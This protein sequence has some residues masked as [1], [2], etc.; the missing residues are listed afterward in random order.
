MSKMK[1]ETINL[2]EGHIM[3]DSTVAY[4]GNS[5]W[6]KN[7]SKTYCREQFHRRQETKSPCFYYVPQVS[8]E[9]F[10]AKFIRIEKIIGI[11]EHSQLF[12]VNNYMSRPCAV[13]I[14]LSP[15][16]KKY[17]IRQQFLTNL[18]RAINSSIQANNNTDNVFGES[19]YFRQT[20]YSVVRF[21]NGYSK[22]T[23]SRGWYNTFGSLEATSNKRKINEI[24]VKADDHKK[25]PKYK[26]TL[27]NNKIKV[28]R[29]SAI[30]SV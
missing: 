24:L 25:S 1:F 17:K 15:F 7:F 9:R 2:P 10:C 21:L 8:L 14:V 16:W 30:E 22:S 5:F 23:K 13:K 20:K 12:I 4:N 19:S 26:I 6:T 27:E 29:R 11:K 28:R 3:T 18:L